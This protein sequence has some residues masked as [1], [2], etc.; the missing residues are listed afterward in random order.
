MVMETKPVSKIDIYQ[1]GMRGLHDIL[2]A[3]D[4]E[5]FIAMI[6]SEKLD[7]TE[8]RRQYFDQM[9]PEQFL[10]EAEDYELSHPFKGNL[11]AVI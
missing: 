9:E 8:W 2:G 7:Y 6:K 3:V 4:A 10:K 1:R 11:S 5:E